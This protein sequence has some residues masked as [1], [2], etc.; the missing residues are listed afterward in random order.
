[1]F[2]TPSGALFA[3]FAPPPTQRSGKAVPWVSGHCR[4][5]FVKNQYKFASDFKFVPDRCKKATIKVNNWLEKSHTSEFPFT[6]HGAREIRQL[7][8]AA[9]GRYIS[10]GFPEMRAR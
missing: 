7:V 3:P 6:L 8:A 9:S 10:R 5:K 2:I 1:M 4:S